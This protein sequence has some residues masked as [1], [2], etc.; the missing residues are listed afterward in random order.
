MG[1]SLCMVANFGHIK[2]ALI[3]RVLGVFWSGFLHKTT[4]MWSYNRYLRLFGIFK[5]WPK[6]TILH[7]YS[8][9]ILAS[10]GHFQNALIFR[11]IGVFWSDFFHITNLMWSYN[12]YSNRFGI[13]NSDHFG[14]NRALAWWPIF[15]IFKMLSFFEY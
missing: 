1:F 15:A 3:F 9:C 8:P 7:G 6:L 14:W 12:R 5:F 2:N 11:V 13:F 10:F 4:L